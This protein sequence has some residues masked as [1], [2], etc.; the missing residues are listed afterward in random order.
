MSKSA[1]R[2]AFAKLAV[3]IDRRRRWEQ[4]PTPV[5]LAL[6]MGLR[7]SL[8]EQNLY[9]TNEAA[10]RPQ[11]DPRP[12]PG[13]SPPAPSTAPTMTCLPRR[14]G[15]GNAV[16][17]QRPAAPHTAGARREVDET[18]PVRREHSLARPRSADSS[19]R[20][21]P[22]NGTRSGAWQASYPELITSGDREPWRAD[23]RCGPWCRDGWRTS[24]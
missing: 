4:F 19:D 1:L 11:L 12:A 15:R 24:A 8:R 20:P 9:E 6:L 13:G 16:R 23:V 17:A 5:S 2:R 3:A 18:E 14:W 21:R 10:F 7:G 22:T